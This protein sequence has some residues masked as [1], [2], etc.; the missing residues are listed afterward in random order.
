VTKLAPQLAT[1]TATKVHANG[2]PKSEPEVNFVTV[3][4]KDEHE[5]VILVADMDGVRALRDRG[6]NSGTLVMCPKTGDNTRFAVFS[7]KAGKIET[8]TDVTR[9]QQ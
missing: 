5:E 8:V 4:I 6:L 7:L 1:T 9:K 3:R 2:K